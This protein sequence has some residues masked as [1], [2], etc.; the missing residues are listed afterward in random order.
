[1]NIDIAIFIGFLAVNLVV[2]LR[3]GRDVKTIGDYALGGRNFSTAAL[4]S[5]IVATWV[6]GSGFFLT[7]SNTYSDGLYYLIAACGMSLSLIATAFI[8]VPRMHEFLGNTSVAEAM[9]NLYGTEIRLITAICGILGNIGGI[10]VQFKVF[11]NVFHYFLGIDGTN[12]ILIASFIV[13]IYSAFGGIRAVTYTDIVQFITFGFVVPVIGIIVWNSVFDSGFSLAVATQAPKFN[14]SEVI[15]FGNP[16]FWQMIPLLLYFAVPTIDAM[17]FQRIS[18]GR[19]LAQVKKA[20]LISAVFLVLIELI[21]AWIPFLIQAV[22]PTLDPN[23]I[24]VYIVEN[25]THTGLKGLIIIGI[26]AMAMSTADSRINASSV[27]F[28]N[29]I[30]KMFNLKIN[31]LLASKLFSLSLGIFG[32]YLALS[33]NDLLSI[34]MTSASLYMPI[35]TV[36]F[37]AAILGFRS[38]KLSVL[39]GMA[40]GF[41]IIV[42]GNI[43]NINADIIIWGMVINFIFLFGSHYMLKQPG[44]WVGIKNNDYLN[45]VRAN[46]KRTIARLPGAIKAFSF[47]EFCKKTAPKNELMYTGLGIYCIFLTI[48][49]MYSTQVELLKENGRIILTIYQIMMC[50]GTVMAMY[51]IWPLRIKHEIIVQVAWNIVIF[52]MLIFFSCFF[53]MVSNFG[54]LQ[55]TIFT[56]NMIITAILV[57]WKLSAG[58]MIVG[59]YLSV[60]FYK[61]YAIGESPDISLGSPQFIFMYSLMLIGSA[62]IIFL[63]PKQE[64]LE[65]TEEKVEVLENEVIHLDHEITGLNGKVTDL[66]EQVTH[67]SQRAADQE[68]EIDRLG[69]TAQ[70]I[71]N[72]VNHELRLPIGNVV[73]FSEMLYETLGKSDNKLVKEMS[74]EVYDNSNRVS[75]MILNMLDL[76]TLDVK[77]VDLQKKTI[78]FG[79][80]VEDRVKTCRK[81]Y[82]RD[83]KIDFELRIE[84]E[85]MIAVDPN[86]IRQTIDNLVINA[87]N[88]STEGLIK[89]SVSKQKGHV[90]FTI[91]DQ[92]KGIPK[93][94]LSNIFTPF[95]MGT[96]SESKACGRGVGLALC[97]SAVEAHGG[98]ISADSNGEV[99]ATL[100]V[101]LPI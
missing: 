23:D 72:N 101:V 99:G 44:G 31:E 20:L 70:K 16:K 87:I 48:S 30:T 61:F 33:K 52:Y 45:E 9:G 89:V 74:K 2:G 56:M 47:I 54:Q 98:S 97:K 80:L 60:Q 85:I 24:I 7:L 63:K 37:L 35:I 92:G 41:T 32:I 12:A 13:I 53:V 84:P 15:N 68:K 95:K 28:G 19:N 26:A 25:Y 10:A 81:I 76:A 73:N 40:A 59:F 75:T 78:N 71:L 51:P 64:Y 18:M 11:G 88:F 91:M 94:E 29:D 36:P 34:V 67:Y 38:S 14:L 4:V 50:T 5:T 79:E 69:A 55:F 66:N 77:K 39:M 42:F 100:K 86:Y 49:T 1:M 46:R 17:D 83:K 57:G 8:F 58:M 62:L 43:Y 6:S 90:M 82:L 65:A 93:D 22:N 3:Y 27:L 21:T 96:N